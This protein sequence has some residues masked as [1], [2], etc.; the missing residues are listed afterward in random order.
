M[1]ISS[2][3]IA[4]R[5][6]I[7]IRIA[8][9]AGELGLRCVCVHPE[10]DAQ[11]LHVRAGDAAF[12]LPGR[13]AAAYLDGAAV[14]AAAR[15]TGCDAV[16]PG[17]G[18]LSEN[19]DFAAQCAAAG[20][21]FVG[22]PPEV[23]RILGDKARARAL[24][25]E[26]DVP[27]LPGTSGGATAEEIAAFLEE[28]GAN[29]AAMIKAVAGGGGRGMRAVSAP[30]EVAEA[31]ARCQSEAASAF[32]DGALYAERLVRRARHIEVQVI[33]DGQ[34]VIH[35]HERDC[36]LQRQNQKL[37]EIAPA[38][39][40][41]PGLRQA[42]LDAALR[43]ARHFPYRGLGTFEFLVDL[44]AP[45]TATSSSFFFMEANPR[46]QVEHTVTEEATGLDLVAT[47]IEIAAG[48]SLAELGLATSPP[49]RPG[50]VVQL[51]LNM[52]SMTAS[53][54]VRPEGG[55]LTRYEPPS[56]PGIRVDGY[57]YGGYPTNPRF[58][59]LLAKL[60][61]RSAAPDLAA[62]IAK[63]RRALAE[64]R[65][66]GVRTNRAFLDA[67]LA[68]P[69]IASW[70]VHTTFVRDHA[71]SILTAMPPETAG[72]EPI[73]DGPVEKGPQAAGAERAGPEGAHALRAHLQGAVCAVEVA[74][75]ETIRTGQQVAVLEAMKME[76]PVLASCGGAV[77]RIDVAP[78]DALAEGAPI[79]WLDP[80]AQ[81]AG[82]TQA[83]AVQID[84]E[85]IRPDLA[86]VLERHRRGL[87]A[88]RPKAV[89][90]RR[91]RNQRT[92]R[93]NLDD[94]FD[95]GSFTEY[96]ALA[97]AAQRQRRTPEELIDM[98]PADGLVAGIGTVNAGH[99]GAER[100]AL[101]GLAY[102]FTVFAGT[103]G[104]MNHKKKDR[105]FELALKWRLPV[106]LFGEGGGGRPGE[107]DGLMVHGLD[108]PSFGRFAALSGEVP[109]IAIVSGRCFAGNAAL[110]G[111]CDLIIA[112]RDSNLG[113]GGP[114][115]VEGGGLGVFTPEEIGPVEVQ[116]ANG[117]VDLVAEDEAE[118]VRL[119]KH[120]LAMAQGAL[121]DWRCADQRLLRWMVPEN[122]RRLYDIRELAAVLAD[123]GSLIELRAGF[124]PGMMT[125]F[126]RIEGRPMGLIA[127]DPAYL[128]GAIDA[129]GAE[130]AAAFMRLCDSFGL[131]ILSLCDTPGF[132][133][134]PDA[135]REG[136]VRSSAAMFVAAAKLRV[137]IFTVVLRKGYGLG[138]QSMAAGGLHSPMFTVA[139][140]TG[141]FGGM[142]LEGAVRLG[143]RRELEGIAD[144]VERQRFF[145][146]KLA[147]LYAVG[148]AVS[149]AGFLEIDA[150]IDP[151]D[152]R[153]WIAAGLRAAAREERRPGRH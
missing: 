151:A 139:W 65:L 71:A 96:G 25:R 127:N 48:R 124:A 125:A 83:E 30:A 34:E 98:S 142:G 68:R 38:P 49:L 1:A 12:L 82:E 150:V 72:D 143:Y 50:H 102:D 92:A 89:A 39:G 136:Q 67:L 138:A 66:S 10:D 54:E 95:P 17:Y 28:L 149:M 140:P 122:R 119:T 81:A 103:Q 145:D 40:L 94:L 133:V 63:A 31:W 53:G 32:G 104:W 73:E 45:A 129:R 69:E 107:T 44:D 120:C 22:P 148:T 47:Q 24:A 4:N 141:E 75:G 135:E 152:T 58:D 99:F 6:E 8:R 115:M 90:R 2:L 134:G 146:E 79:L 97:L 114:A 93:E 46:L 56:G 70:S 153:A 113:M 52:E 147:H 51:R 110:V 106:V 77:R 84:L 21:T 80:D 117:V 128:G 7:A 41:E 116:S 111:I 13:G 60:I 9:A 55:V 109:L 57:G 132:M 101:M 62:T 26:L 121:P 131:P 43:M 59:S 100:A 137:P 86:A 130:K 23:L 91:A 105:L 61:L 108:T 16:H 42:I 20:L 76:H 36:T 144:P 33:G 27:L 11:S 29:G 19:A 35:A 37:V 74:V 112:T 64:F 87:D 15:A 14:I 18:F 3:L 118:A 78:G 88:G 85:A 123:E 126:L 5:G